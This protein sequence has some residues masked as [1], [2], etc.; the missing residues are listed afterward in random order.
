MQGLYLGNRAKANILVEGWNISPGADVF[1]ATTTHPDGEAPMAPDD[2]LPETDDVILDPV[3][4]DVAESVAPTTATDKIKAAA[5]K[6]EEKTAGIRAQATDAARA[7]A[8]EGKDRAVNG[9]DSVQKLIDDAATTIDDKLGTQYGDYAR[10]A[11][12]AVSGFT[13]SL[14]D[15]EIDDLVADARD[16]VRKSPAIA[17]GTAAALGF[18]VAR[19]I[20]AGATAMADEAAAMSKPASAPTADEPAYSPPAEEP[21][22]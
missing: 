14:R 21:A 11:A 7:Y 20:K 6:V 19:L 18:I 9:L 5:K 2:I 15:K 4:P 8:A 12:E 16:A 1:A 10:Q 13:A 3:N 22:V 17:I